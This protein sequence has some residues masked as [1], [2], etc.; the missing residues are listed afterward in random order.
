MAVAEIRQK[1]KKKIVVTGNRTRCIPLRK[2]EIDAACLHDP[3]R[4]YHLSS[5]AR[6]TIRLQ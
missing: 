3:V 2:L 5:C 4:N 6:E 1:K